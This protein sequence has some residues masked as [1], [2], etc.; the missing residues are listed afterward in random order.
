MSKRYRVEIPL[1]GGATYSYALIGDLVEQF[2]PDPSHG[3]I[4][5]EANHRVF[6]ADLEVYGRDTVETLRFLG[7]YRLHLACDCESKNAYSNNISDPG[8]RDPK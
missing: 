1:P 8:E 3:L 5:I 7:A 2:R 4:T 6:L